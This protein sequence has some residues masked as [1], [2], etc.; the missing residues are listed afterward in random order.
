MTHRERY[1]RCLTGRDADRPPYWLLWSPWKS[2]RRRW[3]REGMP[4]VENHRDLFDTD[5]R[6][7]V[8]PVHYGPFPSPYRIVGEDAESIVYYDSWGV[9]RRE[10]KRSESMPQFLEFPVRT[11]GEWEEFRDRT[12]FIL[13]SDKNVGK[14]TFLNLALSRLRTAGCRPAYLTIGVDGEK[15]D[16]I[17]GAR[18]PDASPARRSASAAR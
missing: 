14:T 4:D 3:L 7:A 2:T 13:G 10:F 15:F 5:P 12:T 16:L 11:R 18:K 8:V 6:P 9:K 1:I 17:S